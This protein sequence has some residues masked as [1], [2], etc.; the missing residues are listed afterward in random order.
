MRYHI[1]RRASG[2]SGSQPTM[3]EDWA[4]RSSASGVFY[5]NN[6]NFTTLQQLT[7][8]NYGTP[9]G[10]PFAQLETVNKLSG[11]AACRSN[12]LKTSN[13]G[14]Q[15]NYRHSW[16][17]PV[18]SQTK[19][20]PKK[21]FYYQYAIYIPSYVLDHRFS[22]TGDQASSHKFCIIQEPDNSFG[23]GE[24]VTVNPAFRKAVTCYRIT[25]SSG[26]ASHSW[27]TLPNM[28]DSPSTSRNT[29]S[30]IDAGPQSDGL[31]GTDANNQDLFERRYGYLIGYQDGTT[32]YGTPLSAQGQPDPDQ[33]VNGPTW[34]A[35]AWNVVEFYIDYTTQTLRMWHAVY[36]QA[37]RLVI[38][39]DGTADL[40]NRT[41]NYT[42]AQL[43]PRLEERLA[44]ATR[45]DTYV[46][47]DEVLASNNPINF[48]GGFSPPGTTALSI[49]AQN[50]AAGSSVLLSDTG[51]N[52]G[53]PQWINWQQ[54][55][56]YDP[57]RQSAIALIMRQSS[58]NPTNITKICVYTESTNSWVVTDFNFPL[59]SRSHS[60]DMHAYDHATGTSYY[61]ESGGLVHRIAKH[62]YSDGPTTWTYFGDDPASFG[63]STNILY[64]ATNPD[65]FVSASTAVVFMPNLF[66]AGDAGLV[67]GTQFGLIAWRFSI[68]NYVVLYT[69]TQ[70]TAFSGGAAQDSPAATYCRGLD[71]V[72]WSQGEFGT[73][74]LKIANGPVITQMAN[75]PIRLMHDQG[76]NNAAKTSDDPNEGQTWYAFE[77]NGSGTN[78][79]WKWNNSTQ[80]L[81]QLSGATSPWGA[82]DPENFMTTPAYGHGVVFGVEENGS[83]GRG[84]LWKPPA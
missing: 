54:R 57:Q 39:A 66:G 48:P 47:Y 84:K 8:S 50:L 33:S 55:F 44:D 15:F 19:G 3:D 30:T 38:N 52:F 62:N 37:P 31:G 6:F 64:T 42:G 21:T 43:L 29:Y 77:F 14:D 59:S 26:S 51:N 28:P 49:A 11:S 61:L 24:V 71:C 35:D 16:V 2:S 82:T 13:E 67:I 41:D 65:S 53:G 45:E 27:R 73:G 81:Q 75:T 32:N 79:V 70:W 83:G 36:G 5:A 7:D 34:V 72:F 22:T 74:L 4:A 63:V 10:T 20:T 69:R 76:G 25:E 46:I 68:S 17:M 56:H 40:G 60:W 80:T 18:G 58:Q 23:A 12:I 1:L 78:R 9:P